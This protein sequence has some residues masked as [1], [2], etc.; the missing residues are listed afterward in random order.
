MY[1]NGL[2]LGMV[3]TTI[4]IVQPEIQRDPLQE[5]T[6]LSVVAPGTTT[7]TAPGVSGRLSVTTSIQP[8]RTSATGSAAFS[9]SRKRVCKMRTV[10]A[11]G[12]C[13]LNS[14]FRGSRGERS[15]GLFYFIVDIIHN[16]SYGF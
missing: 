1:G 8:L 15:L 2:T 12:F 16:L 13:F 11:A 9:R 4:V 7:T 14:N 6:E 10:L 3:A 5:D